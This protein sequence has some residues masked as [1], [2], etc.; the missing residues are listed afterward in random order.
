MM[1]IS[2]MWAESY[3]KENPGA[4]VQISG[5][6]SGLGITA[7]INGDIDICQSSR[8]MKSSEKQ[9]ISVRNGA[10]VTEI[11]V[12]M[13]GVSIYVNNSNLIPSLTLPQLKAIYTGKVKNWRE[14][15][16]RNAKIVVYGRDANSGTNSFFIEH[17]LKTDEYARSIRILPGT[18]AIVQEISKDPAAVGY[19]GI[20]YASNV[21]VVPIR[22]DDESQAVIPTLLTVQSG[23]YALSRS[24]FFY[25]LGNP[26]GEVS[27]F[28]D[29]ILGPKGQE[30]CTS[31][32]YFPIAK[33]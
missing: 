5:G 17:V 9:Q 19:G 23:E 24:L 3:V 15:G 11:P 25:T 29:W 18:A 26:S 32:G 2:Q 14:L 1:K 13:D 16:G 6:G 27:L 12:A 28:V 7:L 33:K 4:K 20:A 22:R 8:P 31:A 21:R 10:Y 30:L